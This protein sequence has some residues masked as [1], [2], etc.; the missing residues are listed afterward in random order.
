MLFDIKKPHSHSPPLNEHDPILC[1][2]IE[3]M[4]GGQVLAGGSRLSSSCHRYNASTWT[5]NATNT[6]SP[7]AN[8]PDYLGISNCIQPSYRFIF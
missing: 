3:I 7:A 6:T 2:R 5:L 1:V 4:G 8:R